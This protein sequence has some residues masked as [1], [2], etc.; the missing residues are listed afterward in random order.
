MRLFDRAIERLFRT[1]ED[2]QELFYPWGSWG[3]GYIIP[4]DKDYQRLRRGITLWLNLGMPLLV[5][6]MSSIIHYTER[7][8]D[9]LW[10]GIISGALVAISV[11]AS[12]QAWVRTHCRRLEATN[13][14]YWPYAGD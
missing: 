4:S 5:I 12:H 11:E 13:R 8:T 10:T 14:K 7:V 3:R 6:F 2:G 9:S 1:T